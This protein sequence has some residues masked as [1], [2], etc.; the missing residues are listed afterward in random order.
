MLSRLVQFLTTDIWRI[1]LRN[2]PRSKSFFLKQLR[3]FLLSIRGFIE[4]KCKFRASAL[5]F[6]T[7]LSIVP[8]IAMMF[9]IAKGFGLQ[10][11]VEA[12]LLSLANEMDS[13]LTEVVRLQAMGAKDAARYVPDIVKRMREQSAQ[14]KQFERESVMI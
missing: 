13:I 4:D 6:F 14:L 7:L 3:I 10:D 1:R 5:T 9:G 2:Y 12:Q 11:R 8:V